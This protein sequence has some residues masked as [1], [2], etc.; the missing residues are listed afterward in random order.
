MTDDLDTRLSEL[1]EKATNRPWRVQNPLFTQNPR[2]LH[3]IGPTIGDGVVAKLPARRGAYDAHLIV[4]TINALLQPP[5][6]RKADSD[7]KAA[8]NT[9]LR[10]IVSHATGGASQDTEASVNDICVRITQRSNA[11]YEAGKKA[12]AELIEELKRALQQI[13][14]PV[15]DVGETTMQKI[16]RAAL[17]GAKP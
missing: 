13:A 3:I 5:A 14:Y 7:E 8:L 10:M 9:K 2:W 6:S 11:V 12:T 1:L 15:S 16:A 17:Q 4:E